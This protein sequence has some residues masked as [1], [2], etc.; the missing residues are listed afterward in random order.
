MDL[1]ALKDANNFF[2]YEFKDSINNI[3]IDDVNRFRRSK[4]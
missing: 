1:D 3:Y 2:F 4:H